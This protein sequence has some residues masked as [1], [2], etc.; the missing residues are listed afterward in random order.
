MTVEIINN[1]PNEVLDLTGGADASTDT[2]VQEGEEQTPDTS[3]ESEGATTTEDGSTDTSTDG[4]GSTD[5][6]SDTD[7]D[8]DSADDVEGEFYFG[9]ER[10]NIEV[11]DEVSNALKEAGVDQSELLGQLF[12]KGGDFSISDDMRSKLEDKFGKTM[13]DGYLNMYKGINEQAM[14]K[15]AADRE[16]QAALETE[17]GKQYAEAVGGEEGLVAMEDYITK[18]FSDE[19]IAAYNSVM[20]TGDF[21][22]QML[23]ISQVKQM[24][25][26]AA[27]LQ[28]GDTKVNLIGDK[29]A[30]NSG[31][32]TPMDKGYLTAAEYDKIMDSDKYWTDSAY[33][34]KVDAARMAGF[35]HDQ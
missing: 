28:N 15:I 11:P 17:Q 32:S 5:D 35:K 26:M 30:G 9:E 23:I 22:S 34:A 31:I 18:N 8:T 2:T 4:E 16:A 24:Q 25:D 1:N 29:D 12:K 21:A 3:M 6:S 33:A 20:E 27:K 14:T 13:V 7:G 19:Q 10:V